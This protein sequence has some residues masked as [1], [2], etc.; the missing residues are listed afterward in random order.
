MM[1]GGRVYWEMD[2]GG[3]NGGVVVMFAWSSISENH[4]A[5]FVHLYSSLGWN[6]LVCRADFLTAFYPEMALSL[7]FHLLSDLVE[8]LRTRPCPVIFLALS[9]APK[10]CMY[11]VIMGDCEAQI[12][13]DDSQLVRNCLSGHVYDSGP[14]DFTSDL[15][16]KFALH[17]TIRQMSVPSRL[18]S[19]VA[20]GVSSGLEGLYLTRFESQRSEYWQALYSSVEIGAPY[21]ILCSDNDELAPHQV[22]SSFTHQLQELG[23]EVKVV[24]WKNSPH[25]GHYRHNPIQYRAVISNFLEKAISVHSQKIRQLGERFHTHD[26]IS[27]LICDL[28]KVAVNSNQ[29]LRRV[30]TGPSDHFFLPSSAPYQTNNNNDASSS[31]EEQRDRSSFRPLQPTSIN[32]HSVLGQFLFDSCVPKNIEGWDIRFGG[33]LNGQPYATSTSRKS[34]N[35]GFKKRVLRSRL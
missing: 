2:D 23:G 5:S 22:I 31:L 35:L 14:L 24:K 20:K 19:W 8:E 25:A 4:L 7:A 15:N 34:M 30:A 29:S 13:P 6:S 16:A 9:G 18:V 1:G 17:P 33:S 32:A 27:E 3:C 21:L 10:A 26:E 28:Q 12:L 11:K